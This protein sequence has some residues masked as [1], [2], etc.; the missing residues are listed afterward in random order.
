MVRG[1]WGGVRV[2]LV[3]PHLA[4]C[5]EYGDTEFLHGVNPR[6]PFRRESLTFLVSGLA[7]GAMAQ[8]GKGR[9][10]GNRWCPHVQGTLNL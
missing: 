7:L 2:L 8:V 3:S 9:G 5:G 4:G 1:G 10:S 6:Y